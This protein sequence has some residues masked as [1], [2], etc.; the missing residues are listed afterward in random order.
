MQTGKNP[1][2]NITLSKPR[3]FAIISISVLA[4]LA[5]PV[6]I[7]HINQPSMIYHIL[8]H[9]ATVIITIFISVI[10]IISY[11]R[12]H[13]TKILLMTFGFLALAGAEVLHLLTATRSI[14]NFVIP[15]VNIELSH[16]VLL[17]MVTLFGTGVL[18]VN[19]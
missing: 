12:T 8:L 17:A 1:I 18:K 7:P 5:A 19:K 16:I 4:I 2:G 10:S 9:V 14:T 3:L 15:F 11:T 6:I 13:N